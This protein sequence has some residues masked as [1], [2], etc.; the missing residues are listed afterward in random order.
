MPSD[1]RP[2]QV[3]KV[4]PTGGAVIAL[5]LGLSVSAPAFRH[6]LRRAPATA[7]ALRPTPL[8]HR[9]ITLGSVNQTLKLQHAVSM[10]SVVYGLNPPLPRIRLRL[11]ETH[12]EPKRLTGKGTK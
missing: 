6:R 4:P 8:P 12:I 7:H 9:V 10:R 2:G 3:I 5:P 1:N 11:P